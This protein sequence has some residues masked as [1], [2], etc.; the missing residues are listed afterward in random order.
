[1]AMTKTINRDELKAK[2]DHGETFHLVEALAEDEFQKGHLPGAINLPPDQV[3]PLAP[4]ILPHQREEVVVYCGSAQCNA[5]E[6]VARELASLGYT[7]VRRFVGGKQEWT[8]AGLPIE[9]AK[10]PATAV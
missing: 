6:N 3:Q 5:S 10:E 4:R 2:I 9:G 7:N 1:M 8:S